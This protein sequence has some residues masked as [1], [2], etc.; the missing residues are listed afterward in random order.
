MPQSAGRRPGSNL[1][2]QKGRSRRPRLRFQ[3]FIHI[4]GVNRCA[5][6]SHHHTITMLP[7]NVVG[8]VLALLFARSARWGQRLRVPSFRLWH[9]PEFE[10]RRL[11][12]REVRAAEQHNASSITSHRR[13]GF[14]RRYLALHLQAARKSNRLLGL[15]EGK[16]PRGAILR[17]HWPGDQ[18][19][20]PSVKA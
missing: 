7:T 12:I 20:V 8:F 2:E 13:Y 16:V 14:Q 6:Q 18:G 19:N 17:L 15:R 5:A 10:R 9:R 1:P 3:N 11:P 4:A